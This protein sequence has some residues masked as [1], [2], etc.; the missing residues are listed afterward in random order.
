MAMEF[1]WGDPFHRLRHIFMSRGLFRTIVGGWSLRSNNG[2][3]IKDGHDK[4]LIDELEGCDKGPDK[5]WS[6][7]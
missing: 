7:R 5:A 2:H 4:L 1:A 3:F 6:K